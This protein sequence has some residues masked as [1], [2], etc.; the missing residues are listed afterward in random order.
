MYWRKDEIGGILSI[1][2]D[3]LLICNIIGVGLVDM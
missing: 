2:L 3:Y 1:F